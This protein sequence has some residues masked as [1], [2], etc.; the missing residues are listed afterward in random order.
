MRWEYPICTEIKFSTLV[1]LKPDVSTVV[2]L[3][4]GKFNSDGGNRDLNADRS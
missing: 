2:E 1:V 3:M 4:P